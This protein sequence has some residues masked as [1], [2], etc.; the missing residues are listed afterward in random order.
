VRPAVNSGYELFQR[1][2]ATPAVQR[3]WRCTAGGA[4]SQ[5]YRL[6][7]RHHLGSVDG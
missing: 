1:V 4:T 7:H 6:L 3:T 2:Q 5:F